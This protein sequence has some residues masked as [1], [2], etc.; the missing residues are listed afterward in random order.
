[1]Q[2]C[3]CC[4]ATETETL[5]RTYT[6]QECNPESDDELESSTYR[7]IR[8]TV[9]ADRQQCNLRMAENAQLLRSIAKQTDDTG[10]EE[11]NA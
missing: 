5:L 1:M 6:T 2:H 8:H 10:A 11:W 3:E 4:H 9:C 7:A